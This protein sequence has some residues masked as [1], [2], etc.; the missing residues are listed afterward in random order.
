MILVALKAMLLGFSVAAPVGP[1]GVLCIRRTLTHGRSVGLACGLGAATADALYGLIAGLG[2]TAVSNAL[3]EVATPLRLVGGVYLAWMGAK[4]FV[5]DPSSGSTSAEPRGVLLAWGTTVGL[6]LTNPMTV[7]SFAAMFSAIAIG[8][9]AGWLG[10]PVIVGGVFAGSAAWWL[11]LST[12]VARMRSRLTP[13]HLRW[14]NRV[15]GVVL[16]GF[17][18]W[19]VAGLAVEG[20]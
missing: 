5:A 7:V 15:S 6:T 18:A 2:V 4:T 16:L 10:V 20:K 9:N 19:A 8:T 14:V 11:A 1:I 3:V 13:A 12:G 17:A